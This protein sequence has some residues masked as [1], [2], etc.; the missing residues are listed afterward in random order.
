MTVKVTKPIKITEAVL[1]ASSIPEP[2]IDNGEIEWV[3]GVTYQPGERAILTT[4]HKLYQCVKETTVRPDLG[5]TGDANESWV[6]VGATNRWAAFDERVFYAQ[7]IS[8]TQTFEL[9]VAPRTSVVAF[10]NLDGISS[11]RVQ[12]QSGGQTFYDKTK[13]TFDLS[14]IYDHY[15][16]WLYETSLVEELIFDDLPP[17]SNVQMLIEI[18]GDGSLGQI[19][20][21]F[22]KVIGTCL[23]DTTSNTI[24]L[25]TQEFDQFGNRKYIPR[26]IIKLNKYEI[27]S[28]K[29]AAPAIERLFKEIAG[30]NALWIGEIG[31]DQLLTTYGYTERS[32]IPYTMPD[33]INYSATVRGSA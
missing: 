30:G 25:S 14:T 1:T 32:P 4:T 3:S 8:G 27:L 7:K 10:L 24:N 12:I 11:V 13:D 16:W 33:N 31:G 9:S 6:L 19:V 22:S 26:P 28:E 29:T 18:T 17:L 20:T 5:A 21:G 23:S 2:D 15:T